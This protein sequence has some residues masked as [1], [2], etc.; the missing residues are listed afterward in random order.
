MITRPKHGGAREGAGRPRKELSDHL[1]KYSVSLDR[2]TVVILLRLGKERGKGNLSS[3]IRLAA[4][5]LKSP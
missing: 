4:Q 3:A 1:A 2:E 5:R